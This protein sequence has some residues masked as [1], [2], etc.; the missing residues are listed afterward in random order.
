[1]PCVCSRKNGPDVLVSDIG[2]PGEDGYALI[3]QVR[4]L[5]RI[6]AARCLLWL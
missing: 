2:M 4:A 5:E 3:R 1:M 6:E